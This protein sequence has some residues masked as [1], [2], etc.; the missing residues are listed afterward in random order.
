MR[1]WR[2]KERQ[3]TERRRDGY[4]L[5]LQPLMT[6][7]AA[8]VPTPHVFPAI[9]V[10]G[11][12]SQ[13]DGGRG[14]GPACSITPFINPHQRGSLTHPDKGRQ[15]ECE[16]KCLCV[17]EKKKQ[18]EKTKKKGFFFLAIVPL[19]NSYG[20]YTVLYILWCFIGTDKSDQNRL[21]SVPGLIWI[22]SSTAYRLFW[23]NYKMAGEGKKT[24]IGM[25]RPILS[26]LKAFRVLNINSFSVGQL[27]FNWTTK[28]NG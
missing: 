23:E 9:P 25:S 26:G 11:Y 13:L 1:V 8:L 3:D 6:C 10:L 18:K 28:L 17:W 12:Y 22:F 7:G 14:H 20:Y 16:S 19:H 5:S 2:V 4:K 21:I 24:K 15:R 27:W